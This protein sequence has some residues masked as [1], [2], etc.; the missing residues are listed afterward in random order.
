MFSSY[1]DKTIIPK[2]DLWIETDQTL[3]AMAAVIGAKQY[4]IRITE[5]LFTELSFVLKCADKGNHVALKLNSFL[6][7]DT[8]LKRMLHL[9]HLRHQVRCF[10]QFLRCI[11]A[12]DHDV[13]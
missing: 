1:D 8:R 11:A 2:S 6:R 9:S 12:G 4:N 10:D 5:A 3:S 13:Q 7:P